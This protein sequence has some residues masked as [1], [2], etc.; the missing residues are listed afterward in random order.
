MS[1]GVL[2]VGTGE[3][4][5]NQAIDSAKSLEKTNNI[6]ASIITTKDIENSN[7]T[8]VFDRVITIDNPYDDL[9]DKIYNLDK[10]PYEK[11]LFLDCDTIILRDIES[12][13]DLLDRVD[14]AASYAT[15]RFKIMSENIPDCLPELNT[16]VLAYRMNECVNNLFTLWERLEQDQIEHG[17]P[18]QGEWV[19]IE[20]AKSLEEVSR[21]GNLYGQTTFREALYQS[22]VSFSILPPEYNYGKTG[23]G[24]ARYDVKILHGQ[25]RHQ[26][27]SL[28]NERTGPRK[29]TPRQLVG[30][31]L[32]YPWEGRKKRLDSFSRVGIWKRKFKSIVGE[33]AQHVGLYDEIRWI[34]DKVRVIVSKKI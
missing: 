18:R 14:V 19:P 15:G 31:T 2:Y 10:T 9:R 8:S 4:F 21:F 6:L 24:Y 1:Q 33:A 22:E 26:L 27:R 25:K 7:D 28:I 30:D 16:A 13:F 12:V 20:G 23:R 29:F 11:T 32:Y 34:R 5:F 17:K 3:R